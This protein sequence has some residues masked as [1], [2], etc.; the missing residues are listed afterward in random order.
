MEINFFLA[1]LAGIIS[2]FS[3]CI[4][5]II[6]SYFAYISGIEITDM[7]ISK[8]KILLHAL[9]FT[10]G[11]TFIFILLSAALGGLSQ[12]LLLNKRVFEIIGGLLILFF[13]LQ[14]AGLI[15]I[16]KKTLHVHSKFLSKNQSP[17]NSFL[18]GIFFAFGWS[19][20]YGPVVGSILTVSINEGGALKGI[21]LLVSYSVGM[22][23]TLMAIAILAAF[24]TKLTSKTKTFSLIFKIVA[25]LLLLYLSI[26]MLTGSTGNIANFL[27]NLYTKYGLL[28]IF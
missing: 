8:R 19:P 20:C 2:V 22:G 13:A 11:F 3:P 25:S 9:L 10:I 21:S 14:T 18:A 17:F 23:L 16:F 1:F 7:K 26:T 28:D 12:I 6:P 5:P 24:T 27:N 4:F 15:K